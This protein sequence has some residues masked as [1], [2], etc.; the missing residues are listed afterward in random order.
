M[1]G[2]KA[3]SG[4]AALRAAGAC[5]LAAVIGACATAPEPRQ[6]IWPEPPS[7]TA[8]PGTPGAPVT[9]PL[10]TAP[11][12][13][14]PPRPI[15]P[16]Y[17]RSAQ[18][19]SGQ[20]VV[21]LLQQAQADRAAGQYELAAAELER[22]LR[23]EPRN[24]FLWSAL[25]QVYLDQGQFEQAR[26]VA[27]KSNS[28]ARGNVYVELENWRTI[29]AALQALGDPVGALQAQARADE[30]ERGLAAPSPEG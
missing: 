23:I 16:Q 8:P 4:A 19:I 24:Y 2:L 3:V 9:S 14:E 10:P 20:A 26:S 21:S 17:P 1:V 28:L 22:A 25:A 18:E 27:Q 29:A 7:R 6:V 5:L 13:V 11:V 12:P 15:A 30:L